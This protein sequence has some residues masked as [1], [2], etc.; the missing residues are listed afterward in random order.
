MPTQSSFA[1]SFPVIMDVSPWSSGHGIAGTDAWWQHT[2]AQ[3][4]HERLDNLM[5]LALLDPTIHD[6]LIVQRD[7]TLFDAFD[8]S[9]D[10]RR[11]LSSIK[12]HTL[13]EFAQAIIA[14]SNP[15][16]RW[17]ESEAA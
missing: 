8:F 7:P 14:A 17:S 5:G 11:W 3:D 16:H 6:R 13:K 12:A 4:E 2:L 15:M 9:A 10:T 1:P